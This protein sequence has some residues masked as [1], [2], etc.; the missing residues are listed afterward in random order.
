MSSGSAKGPDRP[1]LYHK[2]ST[3]P[4]IWRAG[5]RVSIVRTVSTESE[6]RELVHLRVE[7]VDLW[8]DHFL[9]A[10]DARLYG[11]RQREG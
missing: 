5:D 1:R 8:V 4:S 10:R 2:G 6:G 3:T 7:R 9:S 11:E